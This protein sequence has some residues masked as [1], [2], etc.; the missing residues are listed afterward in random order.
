MYKV[1]IVVICQKIKDWDV[2]SRLCNSLIMLDYLS[3]CSLYNADYL[4][5]LEPI[6]RPH[7]WLFIFLQVKNK[8]WLPWVYSWIWHHREQVRQPVSQL[9]LTIEKQVWYAEVSQLLQNGW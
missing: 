3:L 4:F 6:M 5:S 9:L 2:T 8:P 1:Y 7:A